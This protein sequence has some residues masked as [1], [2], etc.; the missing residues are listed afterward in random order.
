L[1]VIPPQQNGAFATDMEDV[2][3]VYERPS[4]E[5]YLVVCMDEKPCQLLDHVRELLPG[6]PVH[7]EKID[8]DEYQRKGTCGIFMFTEPLAGCGMRRSSPRRTK[9]G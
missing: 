3:A 4:D 5:A 1:V 8:N 7:T 6:T 9:T 2:L